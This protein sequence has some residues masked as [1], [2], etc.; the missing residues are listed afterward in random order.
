M[1]TFQGYL[2]VSPWI[3]KIDWSEW[4]ESGT[5]S[6][7]RTRGK[8]LPGPTWGVKKILLLNFLLVHSHLTP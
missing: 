3:E 1:K 2:A 5:L 4:S 8:T 6:I 7:A